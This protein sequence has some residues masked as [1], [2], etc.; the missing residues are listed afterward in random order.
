MRLAKYIVILPRAKKKSKQPNAKRNKT[1]FFGN[2]LVILVIVHWYD[3]L[4]CLVL[5]GDWDGA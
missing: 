3:L 1:I 5:M 2:D 4:V